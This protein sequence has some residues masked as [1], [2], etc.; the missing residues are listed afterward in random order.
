MLGFPL[1]RLDNIPWY[2][3]TFACPF[4]CQW[5][6][7]LLLPLGL[8]IHPAVNVNVLESWLSLLAGP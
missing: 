4:I 6:L 3:A 1:L 8:L 7:R 2:V 5:A